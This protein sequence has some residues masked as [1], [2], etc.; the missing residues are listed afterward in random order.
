MPDIQKYYSDLLKLR[1]RVEECD[2]QALDSI[3]FFLKEANAYT[4]GIPIDLE[5]EVRWEIDKFKRNCMCTKP[6]IIKR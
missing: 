1:T 6:R 5:K 2:I 4:S 3:D